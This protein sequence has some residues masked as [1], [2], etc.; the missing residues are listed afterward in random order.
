[1]RE[2]EIAFDCLKKQMISAPVLQ[3]ADPSK[4]FILQTD[5]SDLGLGAVL[6]QS[7]NGEEHP[8]ALQVA[9]YLQP[10]RSIQLWKRNALPSYGH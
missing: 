5:A 4:P 2:C 10:K 3:V 1:M 8:V 9:S 6:S 7:Q